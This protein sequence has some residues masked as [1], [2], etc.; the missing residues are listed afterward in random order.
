MKTLRDSRRG[1]I[2]GTAFGLAAIA[3]AKGPAKAA[4]FEFRCASDLATAHPSSI[5]MNQMW[6][7]VEQ[8]SGGRIHT[9][10]FPN[11]QLG[12]ELAMLSQL[13]LGAL[14][15]QLISPGNLASVVPATNIVY[16]G[17]A[18]HDAAEALRVFDGPLG[19]YLRSEVAAKGMHACRTIWDSGMIQI[20]SGTH[21]IKVPDD[22]HG[23]K[24]RI[25]ESKITTELFKA[26][27]ANPVALPTA[28]IYSALQTKVVDGTT[29]A[30]VNIQAQK[31]F[32]VQKYICMTNH[33]WNGP[34]LIANAGVWQGLPAD[35]QEI[36]E[37]NNY[38]YA[39]IERADTKIA[40]ETAARQIAS[41]GLIFN[42]IDSP[43]FQSRLRKYYES[44]ASE[45]GPKEW[46][47]L[48]TSIHRHLT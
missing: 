12:G 2:A 23:F 47:L 3:I 42:T 45:F 15:F 11:S 24:I 33:A 36:V 43:A 13:R 46:G 1:F 4:Q 5:R 39:M 41:A 28:E 38:K 6:A 22:F 44:W 30:L 32:E 37:R 27:E 14:Q 18:F 9:Q 35:L 7:A 48:Q 16:L 26:L 40:N 31:W 19:G 21:P 10:F 29:S 34:L 25:T 17:F 8:E 20:T